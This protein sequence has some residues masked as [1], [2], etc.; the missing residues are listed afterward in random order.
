[1]CF[2]L[3]ARQIRDPRLVHEVRR[4]LNS[5]GI[6]PDRL[7]LEITETALLEEGRS[8]WATLRHLKELGIRLSI[9]D[10]GTGYSSLSHLRQFPLDGVK[11]AKPF[12]DH[13][14]A[15]KDQAA[16][17]RAI[18]SLGQILDI[19]VVAE[20]IE[21]QEQAQALLSYGCSIGQGFHYSRPVEPEKIV[22]L[23]EIARLRLA[24][25]LQEAAIV[26]ARLDLGCRALLMPSEP[27]G[28]R[29]P[30]PAAS[31]VQGTPSRR[32]W[33]KSSGLWRTSPLS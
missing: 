30:R 26:P 10:F 23:L 6:N 12:I 7:T 3:S 29:R 22:E 33:A 17:A 11:I 4:T 19:E 5:S 27:A 24:Q 32:A 21:H 31:S 1:M 9:D 14:A 8:T 20:G 18:I 13:V 2:N 15:G 28:P 25:T 16:L